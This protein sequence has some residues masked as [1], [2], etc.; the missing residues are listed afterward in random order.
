VPVEEIYDLTSWIQ[1][2]YISLQ[3]LLRD[4]SFHGI[5]NIYDAWGLRVASLEPHGGNYDLDF[6]SLS[7][8]QYFLEV[9]DFPAPNHRMMDDD[10]RLNF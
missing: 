6:L 7:N 1:V 3:K 10:Q 8:G 9:M 2:N 5:L 4:H